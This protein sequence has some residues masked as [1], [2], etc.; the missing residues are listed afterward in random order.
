MHAVT[1]CVRQDST[2]IV[3][4]CERF[5]LLRI[6]RLSFTRHATS[7][8]HHCPGP[9]SVADK[10][11]QSTTAM[12]CFFTDCERLG[13]YQCSRCKTAKYCS[14]EHQKQH[15]KSHK[16]IC[17]KC[18]DQPVHT[19]EHTPDAVQPAPST[20]LIASAQ[21]SVP[22]ISLSDEEHRHCRCMFCGDELKL[23]SEEA[24]VDHMRVCVALQEQLQSK[25]Q[26]TIPSVVRNKC[27]QNI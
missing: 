25:D 27:K 19:S 9:H 14:P 12:Q 26:F 18:S 6:N 13:V 15:W 22:N 24:A 11:K 3:E 5:A 20:S 7:V 8:V 4:V 17:K 23:S 10:K 16:T 1:R 21:G 2:G